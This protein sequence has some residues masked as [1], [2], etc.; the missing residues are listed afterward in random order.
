MLAGGGWGGQRLFE[1]GVA[2]N[3]GEGFVLKGKLEEGRFGG[4]LHYH[5]SAAK[6]GVADEFARAQR[7][8]LL[9]GGGGCHD[10]G[11]G[12]TVSSASCRCELQ[13][14]GPTRMTLRVGQ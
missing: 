3:K 8:G 4:N 14:V 9:P 2:L 13:K 5:L 6:E 10:C 7:D 1:K 12:C 11:L